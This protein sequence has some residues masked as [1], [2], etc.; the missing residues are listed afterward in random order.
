MSNKTRNTITRTVIAVANKD[1]KQYKIQVQGFDVNGIV[2]D[3]KD[4]PEALVDLTVKVTAG[5]IAI[6]RE[7]A[8]AKV[9][10]VLKAGWSKDDYGVLGEFRTRK[11]IR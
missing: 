10:K 5:N 6:A 8:I 9:R 2:R 3:R 1:S 7:K 11:A 4:N